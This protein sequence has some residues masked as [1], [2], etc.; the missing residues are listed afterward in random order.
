M[1]EPS[2]EK[3]AALLI[4]R[5]RGSVAISRELEYVFKLLHINRKNHATIIQRSPSYLGMIQRIKDY[6]TWGEASADTISLLLR[7][8]GFI[9]G[10]KKLTDDYVKAKLG[11]GSIDE[12]SEAI[13]SSKAEFLKLPDVKPV[14]R[15]H[16]PKGGFHG[17]TK[18]PY[19][20]GELG[21]RGADINKLV[22][23]M[24]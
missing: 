6:A 12:L 11:Y 7:E 14:L 20:E 18:K 9:K 8:R 2:E 15:L 4:L 19:P 21:Y 17:S 24:V 16:P 23:E 10:N 13:S 5:I 3:G 22:K 1:T